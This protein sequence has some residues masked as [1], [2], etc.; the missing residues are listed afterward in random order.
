MTNKGRHLGRDGASEGNQARGAV[1]HVVTVGTFDGV[2]RGHQALVSR[3]RAM[4]DRAGP[5]VRVAALVFDPNPIEVLRPGQAPPRL[6]SFEQKRELL[7]RAGADDVHQ[8]EP[9]MSLLGETPEQ[10]MAEIL[11]RHNMIGIVEG[12]DFHFGKGRG[13]T[14]ETLKALGSKMG[15][16]VEV[17]EPISVVLN[18]HTIAPAR[19]TMVRWLLNNGRVADAARVMGHRYVMEGEVVR[20][21]RRG[22]TIGFPTANLRSQH[23]IPADGVYAG[24]GR[25]ADGRSFAAAISIGTKPTFGTH[26]RAVEAVLLTEGWGIGSTW[27]PLPSLPEYGWRLALEFHGW[28]RDQVKFDSLPQLLDQLGRDCAAVQG[29]IDPNGQAHAALRSG[30]TEVTS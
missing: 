20:G 24:V 26:A 18:D 8:L 7:V 23:M 12:P 27:L 22:R 4:A 19:S 25:V 21:D 11:K 15:F 1:R 6:T 16:M 9:T 13:G 2:H 30:G 14:A 3:A 29:V 10:F 5:D 28:V 17:V